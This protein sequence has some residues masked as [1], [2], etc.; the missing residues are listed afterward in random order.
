M[1]RLLLT[2]SLLLATNNLFADEATPTKTNAPTKATYT[3]SGLHCP[4]C[5]KTVESSLKKLKGVKSI[6]VDWSTKSAKVEFDENVVSAQQLA[7]TIA[8]TPHMMGSGMSYGGWLALS[9]PKVKDETSAKDAEK[10]VRDIKGV[11]K[12]SAS[13]M[14]HTLSVQFTEDGNVNSQQLI[15]ALEKAGF[16]ASNY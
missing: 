15:G 2:A 6:K 5:T 11:A 8:T 14:Q 7:K 12:A 1:N 16:K 4:P 3:I 9:I 13:A 10:A